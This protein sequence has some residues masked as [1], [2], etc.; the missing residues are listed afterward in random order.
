MIYTVELN[1]SDTAR[2]DVWSAWYETY[3][4]TLVSLPGLDTAQRFRA[5]AP[6]AQKWEYLALYTVPSLAV[7]DTEAY[8]NIGGGG[9]ASLAFKG[10]IARRRNVYAGVERMPEISADC[11]VVLSED[12]PHGV[13]LADI[14][15]V[16]LEA[17][18]GARKA[19]ATSFDGAPVHRAIAV[20]GAAI[21][22][23]HGL[24]AL[25]GFA[26]YA[27]VTRQYR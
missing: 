24:A 27:P 10:A 22:E 3:L 17:A 19:G 4:A 5:P 12:S 6:N 20:T 1:F 14:L 8:R 11:R 23:R 2:E 25:D 15:F 13:D 26:V 21:V 16:P 9:N 7:F 18:T